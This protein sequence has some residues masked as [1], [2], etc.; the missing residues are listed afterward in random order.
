MLHFASIERLLGEYRGDDLFTGCIVEKNALGQLVNTRPVDAHRRRIVF[1]FGFR[2]EL[3]DNSPRVEGENRE[4]TLRARCQNEPQGIIG[5]ELLPVLN[6]E[7]VGATLGD[8]PERE[9]AWVRETGPE[10]RTFLIKHGRDSVIA[11]LNLSGMPDLI[12][13]LS[14]RA[15]T[16]AELDRLRAELGDD[17]SAWLPAFCGWNAGATS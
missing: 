5:P 11:R 15:E 2:V 3:G 8:D 7:L 17:P 13:V 10:S 6:D 16:V 1:G 12:K 14:G 4:V 9:L